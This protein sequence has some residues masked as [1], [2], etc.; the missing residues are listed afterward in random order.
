MASW[1][2]S[3]SLPDLKE[4]EKKIGRKT[5]ESLVV[6]IRD[7]AMDCDEK[8]D[9][10]DIDKDNE[11]FSEKIQHLKREMRG[12]RR[13]D[14]QILWQLVAVH[15]GLEALRWLEEEPGGA[16][17]SG[18]S[19]LTGSQS[20][21]GTAEGACWPSLTPSSP[22]HGECSPPRTEPAGVPLSPQQETPQAANQKGQ[23]LPKPALWSEEAGS[24]SG[25]AG[26]E[27]GVRDLMWSIGRNKRTPSC[28][29]GPDPGGSD[30]GTPPGT[31]SQGSGSLPTAPQDYQNSTQAVRTALDNKRPKRGS[32]GGSAPTNH[33]GETKTRGDVAEGRVQRAAGRQGGEEELSVEAALFGYDAQWRWVESQDDVTFL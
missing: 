10:N 18:A 24:T 28:S 4:L 16:L 15:E 31:C 19:S 3:D 6:S 2:S 14:V 7:H 5:P 29:T 23:S 22:V 32:G 13:A 20:S 9:Q 8:G 27:R 1:T 21:L 26:P 12:L 30:T 33:K 25:P 17:A 11:S